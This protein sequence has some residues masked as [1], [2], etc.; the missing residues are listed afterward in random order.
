[1]PVSLADFWRVECDGRDGARHF[2]VHA[3]A[4]RC[5]L[6]ITPDRAAPDQIGRGRIRRICVPNSFAGDYHQYAKLMDAAQEFFA[7]SFAE[8]A[9]KAET[10]RFRA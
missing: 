3:A 10:R 1:M 7:R 8:P 4:P 6:E 2:V 5:S 9:P